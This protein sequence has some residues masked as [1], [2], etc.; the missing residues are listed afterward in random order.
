M[1]DVNLVQLILQEYKVSIADVAGMPHYTAVDYLIDVS[2]DEVS[3]DQLSL[4]GGLRDETQLLMLKG[5]AEEL[6][7]VDQRYWRHLDLCRCVLQYAKD[8]GLPNTYFVDD[9]VF[10]EPNQF[11]GYNSANA[12]VVLSAFIK[13]YLAE[14]VSPVTADSVDESELLSLFIAMNPASLLDNFSE[15][16][17]N[18]A[19]IDQTL[20]CQRLAA[21]QEYVGARQVFEPLLVQAYRERPDLRPTRAPMGVFAVA[22]PVEAFP[23]PAEALPGSESAG[24]APT[25]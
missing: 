18:L 20:L 2:Q 21:P 12:E 4:G 16:F 23:T 3:I 19:D 10:A 22:A 6:T 25:T 24:E 7:D 14:L 15:Y 1:A 13:H 8:A 17:C 11:F 9:N 5:L